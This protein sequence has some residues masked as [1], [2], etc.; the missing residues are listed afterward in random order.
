M[1]LLLHDHSVS[2]LPLQGRDGRGSTPSLHLCHVP[3]VMSQITAAGSNTEIISITTHL[4]I[5]DMCR[6]LMVSKTIFFSK[7]LP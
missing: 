1:L 4:N 7:R 6:E 3:G 5:F 2:D